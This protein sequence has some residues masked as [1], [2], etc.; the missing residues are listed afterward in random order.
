MQIQMK[1]R[2]LLFILLALPTILYAQSSHFIEGVVLDA[3]TRRPVAE[4]VVFYNGTAV[5]AETDKEGKFVVPKY[6]I[7]NTDLVVSHLNY[8]PVSYPSPFNKVPEVILLKPKVRQ[9]R[10]VV[11]TA[12]RFTRAQKMKAFKTYFLGDDLAGKS[13]NILNEDDLMIRYHMDTRSLTAS[14]EKPLKIYNKYLGYTLDFTLLHFEVTF[15]LSNNISGSY[16]TSLFYGFPLYKKIEPDKKYIKRRNDVY[17]ASSQRFFSLLYHN[18]VDDS[19]FYIL[20]KGLRQRQD[21]VF[22]MQ[23]SLS[24]KQ[25]TVRSGVEVQVEGI[26]SS[27]KQHGNPLSLVIQYKNQASSTVRF[28]TWSFM[29]DQYGCIDA[30]DQILYSGEFANERVGKMLP[31]DFKPIE[32][33]P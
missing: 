7:S 15:V 12:D 20:N 22:F 23:D 8:E 17:E 10:E 33:T 30:I 11:V 3:S 29:L 13:C 16:K 26:T 21:S 24:M 14:S 9:L 19:G 6:T 27:G 31:V 2:L 5:Y 28:N 32:K 25:V 4:V 18:K 1:K